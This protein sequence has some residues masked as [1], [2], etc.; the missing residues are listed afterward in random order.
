M[1]QTMRVADDDV[2][3]GEAADAGAGQANL[4]REARSQEAAAMDGDFS[5][6]PVRCRARQKVPAIPDGW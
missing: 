3:H 2:L 6:R 1:V 4:S 5:T